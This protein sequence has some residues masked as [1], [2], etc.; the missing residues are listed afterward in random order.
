MPFLGVVSESSLFCVLVYTK[1]KTLFYYSTFSGD[2]YLRKY[3]ETKLLI[4][5]EEDPFKVNCFINLKLIIYGDFSK[6]FGR[7]RLF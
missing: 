7:T 6:V 3:E 1:L 4:T 2:F 5:N